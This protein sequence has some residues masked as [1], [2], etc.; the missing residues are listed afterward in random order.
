MGD[1]VE[2]SKPVA[3]QGWW[4][5][6]PIIFIAYGLAYLDRASQGFASAAGIDKDLG[7]THGMASLD[8]LCPVVTVRTGGGR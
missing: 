8:I 6:V 7:I 1:I 3:P 2:N 5:L 4:Y